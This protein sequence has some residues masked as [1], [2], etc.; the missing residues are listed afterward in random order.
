MPDDVRVLPAAAMSSTDM[1][2][3]VALSEGLRE[4]TPL[5]R[6][7]YLFFGDSVL[8]LTSTYSIFE[9]YNF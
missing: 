8:L 9:W 4:N 6:H 2:A 7:F 3:P 5:L 1:A